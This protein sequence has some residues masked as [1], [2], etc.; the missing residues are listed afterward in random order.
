[1][2]FIQQFVVGLTL[3]AVYGL[4]ALG[5]TMVYGVLRLINFA[6]GDVFMLGAFAGLLA[7][8][9]LG[10]KQPPDLQHPE[11]ILALVAVF[12]FAMV[13]A[14]IA[15]LLIERIAY[16]PLRNAPRL[17]LLITAIGVSLFVEYSGQVAFSPDTRGF[18]ELLSAKPFISTNFLSI[19]PVQIVIIGVTFVLML[20]L[21]AIVNKTRI[22][23]AMR[24]VSHDRAAA[25][26]MGID[27]DRIIAFTFALGSALAAAG[28]VLQGAYQGSIE[29][30]MGVA[31]GLHAFVAAV[32]GGIGNIRGAMLGGL[33]L[34]F[35][36]TG[37]ASTSLSNYRDAVAFVILIGVLLVRPAGLLGSITAEKV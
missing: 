24:A 2:Q 1:M 35:A 32:M 25:Q 36:E 7:A 28:G 23:R 8:T 26:L 11:R 27:T 6:H 31:V 21:E 22:G 14:A 37:V 13:V 10:L 29:P 34:G 33:L 30:L 9:Q 4:I 17:T 15:G 12:V 16:R 5:Y 20:M 18:P 19:A 3:G